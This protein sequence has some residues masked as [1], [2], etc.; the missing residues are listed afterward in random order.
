MERWTAIPSPFPLMPRLLILLATCGVA[1]CSASTGSQRNERAELHPP[2][3]DSVPPRHADVDLSGDWA[4]G[5]TGE[6][7]VPRIVVRPRCNHSPALW[8]IQQSGD[9]VRA[10]AI[11]ERHAQGVRS[12]QQVSTAA[13]VGRVS[14]LDLTMSIAGSRY[15]L[16]YDSTSGHLRGTLDGAPFW[17]VRQEI[18]RP[19]GC[20]PVP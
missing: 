19:Q 11:P 16:R 7:A 8:L 12:T 3:V 14:G 10:W 6:P 17:A 5:S 15:V 2:A 20:I 18:V 13:A 9:T 4:T 1:A